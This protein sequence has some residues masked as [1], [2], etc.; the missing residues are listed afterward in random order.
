[1]P[2]ILRAG[3]SVKETETEKCTGEHDAEN[4]RQLLGPA[5]VRGILRG[6][7]WG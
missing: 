6:E 4:P 3:G 5:Y 1:M 2:F 7:A